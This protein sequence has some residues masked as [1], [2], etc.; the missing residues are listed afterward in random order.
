MSLRLYVVYCV[1]KCHGIRELDSDRIG[2]RRYSGCVSAC[3]SVASASAHLP[4]RP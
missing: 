1:Q 3:L 4:R 2:S